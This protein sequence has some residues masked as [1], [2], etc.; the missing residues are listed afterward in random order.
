MIE[1]VRR[2]WRTLEG[3]ERVKMLLTLAVLLASSLVQ[4]L[5]VGSILPLMA[6]L[7]TPE[8]IQRNHWLHGLYTFL[9]FTSESHFLFFLGLCSLSAVLL[10]NAF[11]AL[12]QWITVR[13]WGSIQHRLAV[14]LLESYLEAPYVVH[15]RRSPAELKRNVLDEAQGFAGIANLGLQLAASSFLILCI[16]GLLLAVNPILSVFL[17]ALMGGGYGLV[18]LV[19]RRRM[20]RIGRERMDANLQRY[21]MVD[22]GLGGLKELKLLQR[23]SWTMRRFRE[24]S[25]TLTTTLARKS[26]L[27]TLPRYFIEVLGFGGIL[28]V[29]LYLLASHADVRETIPLISIFAFAAYRM[30]PA[31]QSAYNSTMGLRFYAPVALT[32]E[33]E[34]RGVSDGRASEDNTGEEDMPLVFRSAIELRN[35]S[36]RFTS[37][38]GYALR[39]VTLA[40]PWGAFVGFVGE[41][42]AGKSTLADVIL[43][44]LH[45]E[46]GEVR[47]DGVALRGG[48][49]RRWQRLLG[50]VPQDVYLADDTVERNIAFG[51]PPDRIDGNAVREAARLAQVNTFIEQEL[52]EGY[53]TLVGDR[54]VRLSGGQRQRIGIARALYHRPEVLVLD[55]ATSM[56]DGETEA[57]VFSAIENVAHKIT[58]IVIAHRLTTV[59]PADTIYLLER[60]TVTAHGTFSELLESNG[61]FKKMAQGKV[62]A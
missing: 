32:M 39:E 2:F 43:G 30:S 36:F 22:E 8:I 41:T 15:L 24:A 49:T 57:R 19:V 6:V 61:Q 42:G 1:V 17:G 47:V 25:N 26:V 56:L 3:R 40:I 53:Q 13:V 54:G 20:A 12:N 38:R 31:M 5:G 21:K 28:L 18:Y 33:S 55:E 44:L 52:P 35:V 59:R 62:D 23:S 51:L 60:G 10:S 46:T 27:D 4:M 50:Y 48:A 14:R 16:T 7:S 37:D 34:L 45:P 9:G 58:L 11:L 29:V